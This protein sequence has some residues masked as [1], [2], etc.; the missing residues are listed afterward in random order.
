MSA[1]PI[2]QVST[3]DQYRQVRA[4]IETYAASRNFDAALANLFKELDDLPAYYPIILLAYRDE[5]PVGC[6]AF[7]ELEAG[8]CEMKR[9]F[10]LPEYRA[11][12]IGAQL[13]QELI[14]GARE[15]G[16]RV[17]R[18]DTHPSM[19]RAQ[20]LYRSFGFTEIGRYNQNPI[21]GIRFF[22]L[23]LSEGV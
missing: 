11:L 8:I 15:M 21:P 19:L 20:E 13:I 2:I 3:P 10:V 7:Q 5:R 18:L 23:R 14:R 1:T 9:L 12:G 6:V 17:M 4:L 16:Y 22:E